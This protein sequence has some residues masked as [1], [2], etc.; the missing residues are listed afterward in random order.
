MLSQRFWYA[1]PRGA[2]TSY[3]TQTKAEE[4]GNYPRPQP[5]ETTTSAVED[6]PPA[7]KSSATSTDNSGQ[8]VGMT[9]PTAGK[10]TKGQQHQQ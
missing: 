1:S 10:S 8:P 9:T 4:L 7:H 2:K 6:T 5:A 3:S